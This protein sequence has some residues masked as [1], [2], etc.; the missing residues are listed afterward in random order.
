MIQ[1]AC[2]QLDVAFGDPASNAAKAV[3]VLEEQARAGTALLVFPE[4]FLTGYA[5]SSGA[6]ARAIAVGRDALA[7]VQEACDRSDV[8]A[9]IGF[10]EADG[11]TVYNSAALLE[12]GRTPRVY[13]KTHLPELGLDKFVK[14]GDSLPVYETRLGR[15]GVFICFDLRHPECARCLALDGADILVLPT[16]WPVG[17]HAA[18]EHIAPARAAENKV[19]LAACN[20]VGTEN[21]FTFI[22]R[23]GIFGLGGE[24]LARAGDGEEVISARFDPLL[25]RDKRN[26]M[27]PG[28]YETTV[29]E[30][31]RPAL[32]GP[33]TRTD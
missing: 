14:L 9:V 20:R 25:S 4:C 15:I 31:R 19:F 8:L 21:G 13:R 1:V 32:Y 27:V 22:G 7:P 30:S 2:A 23:S 33:V 6:E 29:L 11:D 26:V 3:A 12:P 17:A 5:V 24:S 18:P 10:A 28:A 16:N